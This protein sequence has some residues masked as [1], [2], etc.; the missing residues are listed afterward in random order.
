MEAHNAYSTRHRR[1]RIDK[2]ADWSAMGCFVI[3]E[4]G[5]NHNGNLDLAKK[6]VI[7]AKEAKADAVKFQT[8]SA[9]MLASLGTPKVAYQREYGDETESHYEMLRSL[10]LTERDHF[11]LKA[12]CEKIGVEFM[13]TPYDLESARFLD[14]IL[15]VK[16]FKVASADLV[17]EALHKYISK[18]GKP[19]IVSTG[20]STL[21][22]IE[23]TMSIYGE[24]CKERVTLLHCTSNYPCKDGSVN[25]RT[26][27]TLEKAFGVKVG[28]SD[29]SEG[30]TAAII[31]IAYGAHVIEK[32]LTLDKD[33]KGPDHRA[34]ANAAEFRDLVRDIRRAEIMLGSSQK[35][36]EGEEMEMR[37]VSRKSAR[38]RR[39]IKKGDLITDSCILMLRPGDGING[40]E[41]D[42][43][44]GKHARH[45][46]EEKQLLLPKDVE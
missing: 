7:A 1:G 25:L 38:A 24:S 17:D 19:S 39:S 16:R 21:G 10:E 4:I 31:A 28:F 12:F 44:V 3:A 34:S 22:E 32:H 41:L 27:K 14:V 11:E 6:L 13:S 33:M 8:F 40:S 20:M 36:V 18:T 15:G 26:L 5:V 9:E 23:R 43:I 30:S 42:L 2:M 45:D 35:I 37:S 29:H 46:I